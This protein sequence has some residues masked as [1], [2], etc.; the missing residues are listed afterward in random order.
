[1]GADGWI[2]VCHFDDFKEQFPEVEPQDLHLRVINMLGETIVLGYFGTNIDGS[3]YITPETFIEGSWSYDEYYM[4]ELAEKGIKDQAE[5]A[6]NW[7]E[8][9][10]ETHMVWT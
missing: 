7:F 5:E 4:K 2:V 10:A 6:A 1:M 9:N 3:N 8:S